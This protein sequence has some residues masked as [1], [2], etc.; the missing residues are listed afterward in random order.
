MFK[1][2]K[3]I[4]ET[5]LLLFIAII[6]FQIQIGI[7]IGTEITNGKTNEI[8]F[9]KVISLLWATIALMSLKAMCDMWESLKDAVDDIH[10]LQKKGHLKDVEVRSNAL[11]TQR[12]P[13]NSSME[14]L[15]EEEIEKI[16]LIGHI[17]QN[18]PDRIKN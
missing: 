5:R 11:N 1:F 13:I 3:K 15:P 18:K 6:S 8:T 14:E 17:L 12:Q 2:V 9:Y 7:A 10:A 16:K 4:Q